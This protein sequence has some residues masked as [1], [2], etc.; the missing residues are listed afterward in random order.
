RSP[1]GLGPGSAPPPPEVAFR[2]RCGGKRRPR[3]GA[4]SQTNWLAAELAGV[5]ASLVSFIF[6]ILYRGGRA[7]GLT[8]A[9]EQGTEGEAGG[10]DL[11]EPAGG[12][13]RDQQHP[14]P[15]AR[16]SAESGGRRRRGE[17]DPDPRAGEGLLR[18]PRPQGALDRGAR[19][20]GGKL[21][22]RPQLRAAGAE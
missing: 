22:D 1:P 3:G 21:A 18:R 12:A 8:G 9:C 4:G 15:R 14:R 20:P 5:A 11:A 7:G 2:R 6:F 10:E 19:Q 16:G 17:G 13:E